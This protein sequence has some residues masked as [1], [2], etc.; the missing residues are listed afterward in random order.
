M[1]IELLREE[2]SGGS[3]VFA[4]ALFA[5]KPA[6]SLCEVTFSYIGHTK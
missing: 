2:D 1:M 5:Q 6:G 3:H 4:Q